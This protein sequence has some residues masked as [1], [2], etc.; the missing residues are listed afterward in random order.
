MTAFRVLSISVDDPKQTLL[1]KAVNLRFAVVTALL[2]VCSGA[3]SA[4]VPQSEDELSIARV[5]DRL[6]EAWL[7]G[8]GTAWATEFVSD[9]DFTVWF[10]LGLKGQADIAQ[11]HQFIFD[12]F[13]NQ[14]QVVFGVRQIRIINEDAAVVHLNLSVIKEGEEPPKEPDTVPLAVLKRT[15]ANWKIVAFQ[16][17]PSLQGRFG[18]IRQF[19]KALADIQPAE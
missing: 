3:S 5:F 4:D 17:T 14:T 6:S 8:D 2:I 12:R 7:A 1:E 16:N 18:D 10:G 11:G 15:D 19:K 13:Y 9:A